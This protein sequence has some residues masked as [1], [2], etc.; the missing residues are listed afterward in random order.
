VG[1]AG[2]MAMRR[3]GWVGGDTSLIGTT[4]WSYGFMRSIL[5]IINV[6]IVK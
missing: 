2:D 1:I 4:L 6:S 5:I 3:G